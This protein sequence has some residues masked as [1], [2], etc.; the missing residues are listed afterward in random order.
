M[1]KNDEKGPKSNY[2]NFIKLISE[3]LADNKE[4]HMFAQE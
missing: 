3:H 1:N 2:P 4:K